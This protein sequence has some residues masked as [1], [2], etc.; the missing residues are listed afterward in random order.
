MKKGDKDQTDNH[1][2][3]ALL[4]VVSKRYTSILDNRLYNWLEENDK[5]VDSQACFRKGY[6]NANH[7]FSLNAIIQKYLTKFGGRLYVAFM[8]LKIFI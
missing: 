7:T 4:S 3:I 5:I 6:R 8:D 1:R 2:G